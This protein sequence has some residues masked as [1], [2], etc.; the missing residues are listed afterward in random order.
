MPSDRWTASAIDS[1]GSRSTRFGGAMPGAC[2]RA[3]PADAVNAIAAP[4][5]TK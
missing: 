3:T 2:A 4:T 5:L 1:P